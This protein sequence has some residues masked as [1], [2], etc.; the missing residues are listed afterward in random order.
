MFELY[1]KPGC[2]YCIESKKLIINNVKDT[3]KYKLY[4]YYDNRDWLCR[5][6]YRSVICQ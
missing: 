5:V 2:P 4:E 3:K 1:L 6:S